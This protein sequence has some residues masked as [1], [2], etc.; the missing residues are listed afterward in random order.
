MERIVL[1]AE[2]ATDTVTGSKRCEI[3]RRLGTLERQRRA[4]TARQTQNAF[5]LGDISARV[6][7][8]DVRFRDARAAITS[9]IDAIQ[10]TLEESARTRARLIEMTE[11]MNEHTRAMQQVDA[12]FVRIGEAAEQL[13]VPLTNLSTQTRD[14]LADVRQLSERMDRIDQ[15]NRENDARVARIEQLNRCTENGVITS[16]TDPLM[17]R[18]DARLSRIEQPSRERAARIMPPI[19]CDDEV[20]DDSDASEDGGVGYH[21]RC[22]SMNENKHAYT[23]S[24]NEATEPICSKQLA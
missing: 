23:T 22:V 3:E 21:I 24:A 17:A 9:D 14:I 6:D 5:K 10:D 2:R 19:D 18:L 12:D 20:V 8:A 7:R 11:E 13:D 16:Q 4:Q 15:Q 1:D